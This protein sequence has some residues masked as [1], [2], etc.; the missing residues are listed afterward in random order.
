MRKS[1]VSG[2]KETGSKL[3]AKKAIG[4]ED[5]LEQYGS[6]DDGEQQDNEA[7]S[8]AQERRSAA[9]WA[10]RP[11]YSDGAGG[12]QGGVRQRMYKPSRMI[13]FVFCTEW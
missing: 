10:K 1:K 11:S 6:S 8:Y 12:G 13:N 9:W 7:V 2:S 5:S 3:L 4:R